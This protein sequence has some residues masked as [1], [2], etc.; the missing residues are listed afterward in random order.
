MKPLT[1]LEYK[2]LTPGMKVKCID[3]TLTT[4]LE[5]YKIYKV[6]TICFNCIVVEETP[7]F[8]PFAYSRFTLDL[9]E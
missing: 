9:G 7:H 8:L 4:S 3:H 2:L 1:E 5:K 6:K